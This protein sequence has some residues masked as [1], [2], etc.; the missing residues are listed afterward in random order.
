MKPT[1]QTPS[2]VNSAVATST[3]LVKANRLQPFVSV[4]SENL[5]VIFQVLKL[6]LSKT[7][8]IAI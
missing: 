4:Y 8:K 1:I 2:N 7:K 3:K 5:F 6:I